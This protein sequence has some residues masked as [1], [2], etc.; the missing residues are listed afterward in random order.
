MRA[1]V[2]SAF[3][4]AFVLISIHAPAQTRVQQQSVDF[5]GMATVTRPVDKTYPVSGAARVFISN[6]YGTVRVVP[7]GERVVRV[8]ALIRV[9]AETTAEAERF[10]QQIDVNGAHVGDRI[11]VRTRY[12]NVPIGKST[13]LEISVPSDASIEVENEFGDVYVEGL[14]GDVTLDVRFGEIGLRNIQG[15]VRVQA[16]GQ[17]RLTAQRL[18]GGGTFVLRS[19]SAR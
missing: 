11:E 14:A 3:L 8:Q 18:S 13:D 2:P 12:H 4:A 5:S 1:R 19:L 9:G 16:K 15:A 6:Q 7:W 17:F 10:A